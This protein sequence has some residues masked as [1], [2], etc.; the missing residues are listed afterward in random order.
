MSEDWQRRLVPVAVLVF[1]L[2]IGVLLLRSVLP[3]A[4]G[5]LARHVSHG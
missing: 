5:D 2:A 4:A 3:W 1:G